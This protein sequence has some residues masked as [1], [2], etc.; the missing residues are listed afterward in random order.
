MKI[1]P[2]GCEP[3]STSKQRGRN[4]S[5][6]MRRTPDLIIGFSLVYPER[7]APTTRCCGIAIPVLALRRR[8]RVSTLSSDPLIGA[9]AGPNRYLLRSNG[10]PAASERKKRSGCDLAWSVDA[11]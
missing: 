8:S 11:A 6:S 10:D 3:A 9:H 4:A 1:Q 7:L 2:L 5:R